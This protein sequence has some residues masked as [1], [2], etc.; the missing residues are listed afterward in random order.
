MTDHKQIL[1]KVI[2]DYALRELSTK[3]KP[4]SKTVG[5][6]GIFYDLIEGLSPIGFIS[7]NFWGTS[8]K[9]IKTDDG[10][11]E[12]KMPMKEFEVIA[13]EIVTKLQGEGFL[14]KNGNNYCLNTS[15][16]EIATKAFNMKP[17]KGRTLYKAFDILIYGSLAVVIVLLL[18]GFHFST[19]GSYY[20]GDSPS[21]TSTLTKDSSSSS[22]SGKGKV[23]YEYW[24]GDIPNSYY[25]LNDN[26]E[27]AIK[28]TGKPFMVLEYDTNTHEILNYQFGLSEVTQKKLN[29]PSSSV[30]S[31]D[32]TLDGTAYDF[33]KKL[34]IKNPVVSVV[35]RFSPGYKSSI[36]NGVKSFSSQYGK[37]YIPSGA[38][39]YEGYN[40]E[41]RFNYATI[42]SVSMIGDVKNLDTQDYTGRESDTGAFKLTKRYFVE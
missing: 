34:D 1:E 33:S 40:Q 23:G 22:T 31:F 39:G 18:L 28:I 21:D 7:T 19:D 2:R 8:T 17:R 41:F 14:I 9:N 26:G 6:N 11:V 15:S 16:Q 36:T 12:F 5:N 20:F 42:E 13:Q 29:A 32:P 27:R 10:I 38:G 24:N 37:S 4:F 30:V 35:P 3:S 25:L